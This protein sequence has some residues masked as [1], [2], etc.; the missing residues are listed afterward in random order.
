MIRKLVAWLNKR[1]PE[2]L[3]VTLADWTDL[4]QEVASYNRFG[5][6]IVELNNR[7]IKL[8]K[9]IDNLNTSQGFAKG[10]FKLER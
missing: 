2:Q 1:Y 5:P 7:L 10:G 8:E 6:A 9:N 3:V 4:R